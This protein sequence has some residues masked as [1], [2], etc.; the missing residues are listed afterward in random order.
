[1]ILLAGF[2]WYFTCEQPGYYSELADLGHM[3]LP[4]RKYDGK[5]SPSR[6]DMCKTSKCNSVFG[7]A[8]LIHSPAYYAFCIIAKM[9]LNRLVIL[10]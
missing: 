5:I 4:K 1:M 9:S 7:K 3:Y 6:F 2:Q 10:R 8:F